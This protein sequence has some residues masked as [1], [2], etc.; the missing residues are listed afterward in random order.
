MFLLE[1]TRGLCI[2]FVCALLAKRFGRYELSL[3]MNNR[4]RNQKR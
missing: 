1:L 4:E 2:I 3:Y